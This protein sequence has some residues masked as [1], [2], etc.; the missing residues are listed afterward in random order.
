[1]EKPLPQDKL[2]KFDKLVK[3]IPSE[4]NI[5]DVDKK[6]FSL[7]EN[8]YFNL[9]ENIKDKENKE[10]IIDYFTDKLA[11]IIE[12]RKE[13]EWKIPKDLS[14]EEVERV[15]IEI[16]ELAEAR[17]FQ[18]NFLGKGNFGCVYQTNYNSKICLKYFLTEE[19]RFVKNTLKQEY[20]MHRR[21]YQEIDSQDMTLK[22][23]VPT[24]LI[25]NLSKVKSF[26]AMETVQGYSFKDI[27]NDTDKLLEMFDNDKAKLSQLLDKISDPDYI[28]ALQEDMKRIHKDTGIIHGDIHLGN[29]MISKDL[30]TYLI[31]FG[32]SIDTN[33]VKVLESD[34]EKVENVKDQDLLAIENSL[35]LLKKAIESI[36]DKEVK[37]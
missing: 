13:L 3:E 18:E 16:K 7:T 34:Y 21:V 30:E 28:K 25:S 2:D 8:K 17:K 29:I 11:L 1:M 26:F 22:V 9:I 10:E 12:K 20:E 15:K 19:N 27:L 36:I 32:N 24:H 31:D 33:L 4:L 35:K 23:P 14:P 37:I 5:V 6:K